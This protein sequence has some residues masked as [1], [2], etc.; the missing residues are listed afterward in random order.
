MMATQLHYF[1]T[2]IYLN[3]GQL[4]Y[5]TYHPGTNQ[6]RLTMSLNLINSSLKVLFL[7]TGEGKADII[8][9]IVEQKD[10]QY[11]AS[12]VNPGL[13]GGSIEWYLDSSAGK[14]LSQK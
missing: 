1:P 11:P 9:K 6:T 13:F 5:A 7:V 3:R 10:E 2:V 8:P 14:N 12:H 4:C